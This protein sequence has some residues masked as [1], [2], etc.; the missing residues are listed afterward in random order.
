MGAR[1]ST[2]PSHHSGSSQCRHEGPLR[3]VPG[4]SQDRLNRE[5]SNSP[6]RIRIFFQN[7]HA[8]NGTR[9]LPRERG[10]LRP[11]SRNSDLV[12][13]DHDL[14]QAAATR[15]FKSTPCSVGQQPRHLH[16]AP[17]Q[18]IERPDAC[19]PSA[20]VDLVVVSARRP[21]T[22][23]WESG[24]KVLICT[25]RYAVPCLGGAAGHGEQRH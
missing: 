11:L 23:A 12:E 13:I 19:F 22:R 9:S 20:A 7:P 3:G 6:S 24:P 25:P 2:L 18:G 15:Q 16:S 21:I 1:S 17:T 14:S 10:I 4:C 5:D 8:G